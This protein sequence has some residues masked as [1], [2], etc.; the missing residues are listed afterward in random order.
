MLA[1][2]A[3]SHIAALSSAEGR[4]RRGCAWAEQHAMRG[5]L[6]S[7]MKTKRAAASQMNSILFCRRLK[8][9][10]LVKAGETHGILAKITHS[11][12]HTAHTIAHAAHNRTK[13]KRWKEDGEKASYDGNRS[14]R[15]VCT[16]HGRDGEC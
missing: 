16:H 15:A 5:K 8:P 7:R 3:P 4:P 13:T 10:S 12:A 14:N 2:M 6:K 9:G 1:A 11:C